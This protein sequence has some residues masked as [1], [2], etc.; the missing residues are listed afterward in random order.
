VDKDGEVCGSD[1]FNLSADPHER[2]SLY[3]NPDHSALQQE[4]EQVLTG[5][6]LKVDI[7]PGQLP[8]KLNK[9]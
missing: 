9:Q 6:L 4:M 8:G 5:E 2:I 7:G 3:G 1:L